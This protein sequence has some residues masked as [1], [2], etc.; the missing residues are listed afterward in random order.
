MELLVSV[1]HWPQ[2]A[3][4]KTRLIGYLGGKAGRNQLSLRLDESVAAD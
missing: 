4:T 3:G 1:V 2:P